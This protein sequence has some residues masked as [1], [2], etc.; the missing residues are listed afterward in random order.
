M[1]YIYARLRRGGFTTSDV[2]SW[3]LFVFLCPKR[4]ENTVEA[5]WVDHAGLCGSTLQFLVFRPLAAL[6]PIV[7]ADVLLWC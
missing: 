3:N 7:K 5:Q 6:S 4:C 2:R 1:S